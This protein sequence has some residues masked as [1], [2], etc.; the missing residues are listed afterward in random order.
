M[1]APEAFLRTTFVGGTKKKLNSSSLFSKI[2]C[3]LSQCHRSCGDILIISRFVHVLI[4]SLEGILQ[5]QRKANDHNTAGL[6]TN[7]DGMPFP[8]S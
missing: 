5:P 1:R 3:R 7:S 2:L 8:G 4:V 6:E